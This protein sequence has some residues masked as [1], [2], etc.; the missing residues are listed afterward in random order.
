MNSSLTSPT[1]TQIFRARCPR[2][3]PLSASLTT[4][5]VRPEPTCNTH[6]R[7][8]CLALRQSRMPHECHTSR[9]LLHPAV[10]DQSV[11]GPFRSGTCSPAPPAR[12]SRHLYSSKAGL[13]RRSSW[14]AHMIRSSLKCLTINCSVFFLH[15]E[16][17]F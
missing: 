3:S 8:R 2:V 6:C 4:G 12:Y 14:P 10:S 1:N 11:L 15:R 13:Q 5:I 17:H 16:S 9:L 7:R